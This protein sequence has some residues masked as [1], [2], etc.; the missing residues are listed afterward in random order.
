MQALSNLWRDMGSMK[1]KPNSQTTFSP[2][3]L[4]HISS[5]ETEEIAGARFTIENNTQEK[6]GVF[7]VVLAIWYEDGFTR[8]MLRYAPDQGFFG[9]NIYLGQAIVERGL[10][11]LAKQN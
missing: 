6:T 5:V 11:I 3:D 9:F 1:S 10:R 8:R 4:S 7:R 2:A